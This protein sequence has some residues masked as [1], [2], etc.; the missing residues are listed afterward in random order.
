M[1]ER[2]GE[3]NAAVSAVLLPQRPQGVA[4]SMSC[5]FSVQPLQAGGCREHGAGY[6]RVARP[7]AMV[8]PAETPQQEEQERTL[9]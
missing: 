2:K 9:A 1:G 8:W 5:A 7:A 4:G 6:T 3:E